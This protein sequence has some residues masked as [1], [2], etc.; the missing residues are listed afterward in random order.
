MVLEG[1]GT[2]RMAICSACGYPTLGTH[3]CAVCAP[4]MEDAELV[5]GNLEP[6]A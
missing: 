3:I 6:A 1:A 4:M 5:S 2:K